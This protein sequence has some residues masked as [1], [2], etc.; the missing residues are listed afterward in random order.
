LKQ[1]GTHGSVQTLKNVGLMLTLGNPMSAVTQLGDQAFNIFRH[2]ADALGG[3]AKAIAGIKDPEIAKAFN[4]DAPLK[5]F[6]NTGT[7]QALDRVLKYAGLKGMD[8]FGKESFLQASRAKWSKATTEEFNEQ[9]GDFF[10]NPSQ[11]HKDLKKGNMTEDVHLLLFSELSEF[12]PVSLSETPEF[13]LTSGNLR[14]FYMLKTFAI[15]AINSTVRE[16]RVEWQAGNHYKAARNF[17]ALIGLLTLAGAG[18]DEI[19]DF[20][21]GRESR[22]SDN[23][24]D[25]L[26]QLALINRYSLEKGLRNGQLIETIVQGHMPPF[27]FASDFVVDMVNSAKGEPTYRT[28]KNFPLAGSFVYARTPEGRKR[29]LDSERKRILKDIRKSVSGDISMGEVRKRINKFNRKARR[30]E[31][32]DLISLDSIS[33]MRKVERKKLRE[34]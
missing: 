32:V 25:N 19:K 30:V 11:V 20:M 31:D 24:V 12:Q 29:T 15:K 22:I 16:F 14:I 26:L 21:L 28:M 4:L 27:R 23:I 18:T 8:M 5:E 17:S 6:S 34:K 10:E 2:K 13:F 33:R 7:S 3:M 1:R 9:W